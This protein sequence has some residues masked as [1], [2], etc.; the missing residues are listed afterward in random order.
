MPDSLVCPNRFRRPPGIYHPADTHHPRVPPADVGH[1]FCNPFPLLPH[2]ASLSSPG[3]RIDLG[4]PP[5]LARH[6]PA[7]SAPAVGGHSR[8]APR[9]RGHGSS[10]RAALPDHVAVVDLYPASG[11]DSFFVSAE[12]LR[13]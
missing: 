11:G 9:C 4:F 6:H 1:G 8:S 5:S 10:S 12:L 13:L 3:L 2:L 7:G